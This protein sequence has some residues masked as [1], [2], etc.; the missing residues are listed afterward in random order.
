M[1]LEQKIDV[2]SISYVMEIPANNIKLGWVELK[3]KLTV[4]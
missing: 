4:S 3:T 1:Y 2:K